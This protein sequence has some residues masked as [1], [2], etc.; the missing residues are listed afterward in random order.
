MNIH[1]VIRF[2]GISD[3]KVDELEGTLN[4]DEVGRLEVRVY[5]VVVMNRADALEHFFPI[6]AGEA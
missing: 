5:N 6:V 4:K 1:S 3:T 2:N